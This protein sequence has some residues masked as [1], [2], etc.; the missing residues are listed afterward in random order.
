MPPAPRQLSFGAGSTESR[1]RSEVGLRKEGA[2]CLAGVCAGLPRSS[3]APAPLAP[4]EG[5][6]RQ[7][8]VSNLNVWI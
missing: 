7:K 2:V 3:S 8:S 6:S 1:D 4:T 5:C